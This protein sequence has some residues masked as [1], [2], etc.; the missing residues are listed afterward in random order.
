MA[1]AL[2]AVRVISPPPVQ[3]PFP[4]EPSRV[5]VVDPVTL[6]VKAP[7]A[8]VFPRTPLMEICAPVCNPCEDPV[9]TSIGDLFEADL[10]I[11][12]AT[13]ATV[14]PPVQAPPS[15]PSNVNEV[16]PVT[17]IVHVVFRAL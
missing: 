16:G 7:F 9:V 15:E 1:G 2:K 17:V 6:I 14:P 8:A 10:I 12:G 5:N 11:A 4:M 13:G 3:V